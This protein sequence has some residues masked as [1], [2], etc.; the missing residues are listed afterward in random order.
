MQNVILKIII[1]LITKIL[2][3]NFVAKMTVRLLWQLSQMTDSKVDDGI[4]TD[5][6]E[7]LG[8]DDYK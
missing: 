8:V 2:T 3:E 4:V 1:S 6:A 5:I 7:A